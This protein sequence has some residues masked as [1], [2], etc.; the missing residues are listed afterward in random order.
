MAAARFYGSTHCNVLFLTSV[1]GYSVL[2][3]GLALTPGPF[4]AAAVAGPASRVAERFG[5][6][7]V[8]F[9]GGLVWGGGV[10]WPHLPNLLA[11]LLA[12][13]RVTVEQDSL[14]VKGDRSLAIHSYRW[15][16]DQSDAD[17]SDDDQ[18]DANQSDDDQSEAFATYAFQP[19][20]SKVVPA[21]SV[22]RNASSPALGFGGLDTAAAP[23]ASSSPTPPA[24][25]GAAGSAAAETISAPLT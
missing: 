8:L 13:E 21:A 2:D 19:S 25:P 15:R 6:R 14:R 10:L 11:N 7:P 1:W 17:Q 22:V 4:V 24:K 20:A 5:A 9:A 16:D 23:A 12:P 18:S 3:A